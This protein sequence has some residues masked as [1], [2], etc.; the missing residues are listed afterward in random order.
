MKEAVIRTKIKKALEA[1]GGF[2]A[3]IHQAGYTI[4]GLPDLVGFPT[5]GPNAFRFFGIEV[6]RP[7]TKHTLTDRQKH[8]IRAIRNAGGIA[9]VATCVDDAL[10]IVYTPRK[11]RRSN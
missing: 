7:E 10:H 9:G 4:K 1:K 8:V 6:K 5:D 11:R 2:W 3:V